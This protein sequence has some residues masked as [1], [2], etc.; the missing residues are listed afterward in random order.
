MIVSHSSTTGALALALITEFAGDPVLPSPVP[1]GLAIALAAAAQLPAGDYMVVDENNADPVL[2]DQVCAAYTPGQPPI[3][4]AV[5]DQFGGTAV[6]PYDSEYG[7]AL[8]I[9]TGD[10]GPSAP[11]GTAIY[12]VRVVDGKWYGSPD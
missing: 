5:D 6:Y 11:A 8:R 3:A 12:V 7:E 1:L 10:Y 2:Y 4:T 9:V